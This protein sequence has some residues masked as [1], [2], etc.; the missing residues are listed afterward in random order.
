MMEDF[1]ADIFLY[2]TK[3]LPA[4]FVPDQPPPPFSRNYFFHCLK[5]GESTSFTFLSF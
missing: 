3:Q 4:F 1:L 2:K 5:A